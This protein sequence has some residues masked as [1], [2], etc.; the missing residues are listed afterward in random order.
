MSRS[1][2][3]VKLFSVLQSRPLRLVC[4]SVLEQV[5]EPHIAPDVATLMCEFLC[6]WLQLLMSRRGFFSHHEWVN[7]EM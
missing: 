1:W 3:Q 7:A 5:G 4:P 6:E 2:E